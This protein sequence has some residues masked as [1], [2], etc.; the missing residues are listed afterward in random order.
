VSLRCQMTV[1]FLVRGTVKIP[2]ALAFPETRFLGLA[3]PSGW[4]KLVANRAASNPAGPPPIR[5]QNSISLQNQRLAEPAL[6]GTVS[7]KLGP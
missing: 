1:I 6:P 7:C 3:M 5:P 4:T 2:D